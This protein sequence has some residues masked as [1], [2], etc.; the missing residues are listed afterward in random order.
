MTSRPEDHSLVGA[1][2]MDALDDAEREQFE[3]HLA[4]CRDCT[5]ELRG[6]VETTARLAAAT[7]ANPPEALKSA[8]L[9]AAARTRQLPPSRAGDARIEP[10]RVIT[11]GVGGPLRSSGLAAGSRPR[12][13]AVAA[14]M[15]LLAVAVG[16]FANAQLTAQHRLHRAQR[17]D[18]LVETVLS[19]PDATLLST[20]VATGGTAQ[21]VMAPSKHAL[22]FSASALRPVARTK[23]YELWLIRG[24]RDEPGGTIPASKHDVVGPIPMSGIQPGDI[25]GISVEPAPGSPNPTTPMIAELVL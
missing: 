20:R 10:W 16:V 18:A 3:R 11:R 19:A 5:D 24:G 1:Y 23:S 17:N 8:T 2:A 22:V 13:A 14:V 12:I 15:I 21:V 4:R 25:L 9:S 6:F 7:P